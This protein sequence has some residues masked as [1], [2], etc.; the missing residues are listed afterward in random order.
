M[1]RIFIRPAM[2]FIPFGLGIALQTIFRFSWEVGGVNLSVWCIR[3]ALMAMFLQICLRINLDELKP[4]LAHF[5]IL[6]WNVFMGVVPY[7]ILKCA[8]F[9]ILALAAFF[10]GISPT[11]NAAPVVM[12]FLEGR[13]GFVLTGFAITNLAVDILLV[14]ILPL[15]SGAPSAGFAYAVFSQ[16]FIVAGIP[17]I[18][19]SILRKIYAP[20]KFYSA[21]LAAFN[22]SLW[23]FSLFVIASKTAEFFASSPQIPK[24]ITLEIAIV[25]LLICAANFAI[26]RLFISKKF[27]RESS[28]TL[29]Q[30]NTALTIFL[31]LVFG[32][33]NAALAALGPTFYVLWHNVWNA[34]Q[35]YRHDSQ[36]RRACR[37][38]G[39][40]APK[41]G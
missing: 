7:L 1:W 4:K 26:G 37:A 23:S 13:V 10:A 18:I 30:K 2:I 38:A 32:G 25:S 19:A 31:A 9:E 5:K 39:D 36:K 15:I 22:F 28:Q 33:E 11:A 12:G 41:A 16:L 35:M 6:F 29:G 40:I 24:L 14:A 3:C 20:I 8:G 17:I 34:L 21:K 27:S